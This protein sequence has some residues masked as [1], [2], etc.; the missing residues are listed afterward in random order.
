MRMASRHASYSSIAYAPLRAT[1]AGALDV[2]ARRVLPGHLLR[3]SAVLSSLHPAADAFL[4]RTA[5]TACS[6]EVRANQGLRGVVQGCLKHR[7]PHSQTAGWKR[8][9]LQL[10]LSRG[11]LRVLP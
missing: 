3:R 4:Q 9:C 6:G 7:L 10:H 8:C 11:C 5:V 1:R 2:G